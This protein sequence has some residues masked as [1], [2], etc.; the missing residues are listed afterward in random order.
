[1]HVVYVVPPLGGALAALSGVA[2]V[3]F[4]PA[5]VGATSWREHQALH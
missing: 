2:Y 4:L 1:M 3:A 5:Q